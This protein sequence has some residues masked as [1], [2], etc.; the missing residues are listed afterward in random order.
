MPKKDVPRYTGQVLLRVWLEV[1]LRAKTAE[2]ARIETEQLKVSDVATFDG[3]V[4][5]ENISFVGIHAGHVL[6]KID[7]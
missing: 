3:E 7:S 2:E 5:D 1:P 6:D 4:N